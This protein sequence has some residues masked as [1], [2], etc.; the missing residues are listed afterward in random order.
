[1]TPPR[2]A[3]WLAFILV[4]A[5]AAF[6]RL[7]RLDLIDVRFDEASAPQLALSIVRGNWLPVAPFSGSVANHPPVYLY[8]LALPYLFTRDFMAIAAYRALLDVAA[9]ALCW[10]LC[11][12]FFGVRVALVA[13]LLFAVAP[14]A[15][16]FAR[17]TWLAPM[18]LFST[19]LLFGLLEAIRRRNPWGWA[20]AGWGLALSIGSHLAALY[21]IPVVLVA[22]L[23]GRATLRP[24]PCLVGAL[25]LVA[26]AGVYLGFDAG[27][28]FNNVRSLLGAASGQAVISLD[29]LR[30]T[31][32]L[33]GGTHL[34]DLTGGA[35]PIWR[36]QTPA[37][38]AWIDAL[39]MAWLV[40]GA[41]VLILQ[42]MRRPAIYPAAT[43]AVLLAWLVL[44]VALQL[45]TSRP[46]QLHYF[47]AFYPTS[48]V[49]MALGLDAAIHLTRPRTSPRD[50]NDT[51]DT[52]NIPDP[53]TPPL[54]LTVAAALAVALIVGWQLFTTLRFTQF[55]QE[56]DTGAGGY[57]PPLRSALD[58]TQLARDA[59][60]AG[61]ARD[62]I[63]IAPGD[64]PSVNEP[65]TVM[66]VL[67]ADVPHR[68]ADANAGLI[69]REDGAQYIITPEARD[70]LDRLMQHADADAVVQMIP[71]RAGSDDAYIYVRVNRA[72]LGSLVEWPAQWENGVGMLGYRVAGDETLLLDYYLR[73]FREAAPGVDYH[74]FNHLYH[75]DLKFAALD[76]G[77]IH[78]SNWRAGDI[79]LHHFAI[80]VPAGAPARPYVLH[81]GAYLYPQLQNVMLLDAE[82]RPI[83]DHV[84]LTIE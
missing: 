58:A 51:A 17:R 55:I 40:A 6:L 28:H 83:S 49:V 1:M 22:L 78:P 59:I 56:Y 73:V 33:S 57:G 67:L 71:L 35:F 10:W 39:Q 38:L 69:L 42:L 77:G 84:A 7:Y 70:A 53:S 15:V 5:L 23:V 20:I 54:A 9:I 24:A 27:Q 74:W 11:R 3:E 21:L 50:T 65:A 2:R 32:W 60:R 52:T 8:L 41:G 62:V 44:P 66:D 29:A 36:A 48:F 45:R 37:A 31:L 81:M 19:L 47:T 64:D 18:P 72:Q 4:M 13:C 34:S 68:F 61:N 30:F 25:P 14:W 26:L 63:V 16:H 12:R 76:G 80:P 46:L 82:G 79:L 43:V 75:G